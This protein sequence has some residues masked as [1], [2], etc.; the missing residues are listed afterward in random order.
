MCYRNAALIML[1]T[2]DVFMQ[3]VTWHIEKYAELAHMELLNGESDPLPQ[4]SLLY[5]VYWPNTTKK[6]RQDAIDGFWAYVQKFKRDGRWPRHG[7]HDSEQDAHE[8]LTWIFSNLRTQ[9]QKAGAGLE[10]LITPFNDIVQVAYARRKLCVDCGIG[11]P[12][13]HRIRGPEGEYFLMIDLGQKRGV[14]TSK[15]RAIREVLDDSIQRS[16]TGFRCDECREDWKEKQAKIQDQHVLKTQRSVMEDKAGKEWVRLR[17]LPEVLFMCFERFKWIN[18][19]AKKDKT[20]VALSDEIDIAPILDKTVP[21]EERRHTRYKLRSVISH[22]GS[23]S[24]GHYR[25]YVRV[26]REH[27]DQWFSID[28]EEGS[29]VDFSAVNDDQEEW[30][31]YILCWERIIDDNDELPSADRAQQPFSSTESRSQSK[32]DSSSSALSSLGDN[33]SY[34]LRARRS[35]GSSLSSSSSA[36]SSQLDSQT[37]KESSNSSEKLAP[38]A[39]DFSAPLPARLR[40]RISIDGEYYSFNDLEVLLPPQYDSLMRK[41]G[42]PISVEANLDTGNSLEPLPRWV[43]FDLTAAQMSKPRKNGSRYLTPQ[44]ATSTYQERIDHWQREKRRM[45]P[46]AWEKLETRWKVNRASWLEALSVE[47]QKWMNGVV[48]RGKKAQ[49]TMKARALDTAKPNGPS[50]GATQAGLD[51]STT[52]ST[53]N[54][55]KS[56]RQGVSPELH[57]SKAKE[58]EDEKAVIQRK[59]S[60]RQAQQAQPAQKGFNTSTPQLPPQA[61]KQSSK[62][63]NVQKQK[64]NASATQTTAQPA[65]LSPGVAQ[66]SVAGPPA[67]RTRART[68]QAQQQPTAVPTAAASTSTAAPK[69]T[70]R[71]R[72]DNTTQ[73]AQPV[74]KRSKANTKAPAEKQR[75]KKPTKSTKKAAKKP[76]TKTTKKSS[77][78]PFYAVVTKKPMRQPY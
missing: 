71:K 4:L 23:I 57:T 21:E 72:D 6:Q 13:K 33:D 35:L 52:M 45:G 30:T 54:R 74:P 1:M 20:H 67:C 39:S 2:S 17:L 15:A 56:P 24:T 49:K 12:V 25:N 68:R 43:R 14:P 3:Y 58:H 10:E 77:K 34:F 63:A 78:A 64:S 37:R 76:Q 53:T 73:A 38:G 16:T 70:K 5:Q 48:A 11:K 61:T 40:A 9:L 75:A 55:P 69:S 27:G 60:A 18:G 31:P 41:G 50:D 66:T 62:A 51:T 7:K 59:R 46:E 19:K 47:E 28:D 65:N 42:V 29:K 8:F 44:N 36:K 26:D 22:E 32:S